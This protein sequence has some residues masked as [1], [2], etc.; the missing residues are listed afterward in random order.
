MDI[1]KAKVIATAERLKVYKT[2]NG[3]WYDY[4]NQDEKQPPSAPKAGKKEFQP[5][6]LEVNKHPFKN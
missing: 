3:T 6:E 2:A 5:E 4:D 1:Y